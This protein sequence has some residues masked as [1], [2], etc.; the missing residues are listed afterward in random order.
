[1][2]YFTLKESEKLIKYYTPLVVG[3]STF[4]DVKI[5]QLI[6]E[7]YENNENMIYCIGKRKHP[8]N[9]KKSIIYVAISL[10]LVPPSEFLKTLNQ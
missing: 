1:M 3:K 9:F 10:N 2:E 5:E 6:I 8:L 7:N 4:N